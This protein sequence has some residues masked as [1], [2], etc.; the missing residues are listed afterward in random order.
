[1]SAVNPLAEPESRSRWPSGG[2]A[3]LGVAG[4]ALC[5]LIA[6]GPVAT[7]GVLP[8]L[9]GPARLGLLACAVTL[10]MAPA[11]TPIT[12]QRW[13]LLAVGGI[14]LGALA[15]LLVMPDPNSVAIILL[16]LGVLQASLPG[17]RS[18]AVR[19][20][21]PVTAAALLSLGWLLLRSGS[22]PLG[23]AGALLL[24]LGLVA[25]AALVPYLPELR[26]D[27]PASSSPVP[28]TGLFG[29]ALALSL[30]ARLL[31]MLDGEERAVFGAALLL[32]GVLNLIWG[33]VGAWR[34]AGGSEAW[35]LSFVAEWGLALIGLGL[36]PG[37]GAQA[38]LLALLSLILVRFPLYLWARPVLLG[39]AEPQ[40]RGLNVLTALALAGAAPFAG[41]AV[42]LYA[43]RAAAQFSWLLTALLLLAFLVW[44]AHAFRLA[45][46][47]GTPS[48][49]TTVGVLLT[50]GISLAL[51]LAPGAFLAAGA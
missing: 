17:R 23:R 4:L 28:W 6:L 50:L 20:R 8:P 45:R 16:L 11:F 40:L 32:A 15:A 7:G 49:R 46:T 37:P 30:P 38:A 19:V 33:V 2:T 9:P 42:R 35:R 13:N 41:F 18:F 34:A 25:A 5:L 31:P 14:A 27:E 10:A 12:R 26:S 29:P 47:L 1:M 51:G 48:R 36:Y 22:V 3:G 44:T 39:K 21:A 43:L 24:A